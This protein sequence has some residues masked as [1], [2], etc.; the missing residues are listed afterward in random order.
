M[1]VTVNALFKKSAPAPAKTVKKTVR[2]VVFFLLF[3]ESKFLFI[4]SPARII[5]LFFYKQVPAKKAVPAKK[6]TPAKKAPVTVKKTVKKAAPVKST[7]KTADLS[8]WYGK[9]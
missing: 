6:P 8:K 4:H 7:V 1:A 9:Y 5:N 3:Y 2:S